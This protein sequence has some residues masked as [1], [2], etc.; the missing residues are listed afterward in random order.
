MEP[1][2]LAERY[3]QAAGWAL[4]VAEAVLDGPR[5][6]AVVGP[7]GDVGTEALRRV[8]VLAT[9][10]GA[11]LATGSAVASAD[12]AGVALLRGRRMVE[13]CPTAYV[14]RGFVCDR[15]TTDPGELAVLL[16]P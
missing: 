2:A 7:A 8:A 14:C 11:V 9:A 3:P 15:P 6:V 1:L 5:E 12:A 16:A 13:G 10:P 4:A